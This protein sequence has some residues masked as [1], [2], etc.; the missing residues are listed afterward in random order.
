MGP[1]PFRMTVHGATA[2]DSSRSGLD[3]PSPFLPA[4]A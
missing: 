4:P 1:V 3:P 2:R